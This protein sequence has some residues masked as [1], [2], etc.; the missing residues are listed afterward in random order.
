[1]KVFRFFTSLLFFFF[2]LGTL[3]ATAIA[4]ENRI[5]IWEGLFGFPDGEYMIGN[6]SIGSVK[7]LKYS[8]TAEGIL[9]NIN[10]IKN[11]GGL[12]MSGKILTKF[13]Y[14]GN[15]YMRLSEASMAPPSGECVAFAKAMTGSTSSS[16]W[17]RGKSISGYLIWNGLG[18]RLNDFM[19]T[20][21]V[22][23]TMIAH[24][25]GL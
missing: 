1:M 8:T 16:T 24:F 21:L 23:G 15:F 12:D 17:Y 22:P 13:Q 6:S 18:Y 3:A 11:T 7:T 14:N 2:S 9:R 10:Y 20:I 19:P 25:Q 5:R 4:P